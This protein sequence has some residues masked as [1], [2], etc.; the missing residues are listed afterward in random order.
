MNVLR[1]E[2]QT[3][4]IVQREIGASYPEKDVAPAMVY[5]ARKCSAFSL[6]RTRFRTLCR[7]RFHINAC[8]VAQVLRL[9]RDIIDLRG[10]AAT[11]LIT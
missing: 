8:S 2:M 9:P 4:N 5:I 6:R 3:D 1:Q 7:L 10:N 11:Q